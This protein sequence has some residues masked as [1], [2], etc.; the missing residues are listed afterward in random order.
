[1]DC[2]KFGKY[3]DNFESLTENERLSLTAHASECE[4]CAKELDF[5]MSVIETVKSLPKIEAPADFMERLN[6]RLDEEERKK[7][8]ASRIMHNMSRNWKQYTALAACLALVAVL[9]ANGRLLTDRLTDTGDGVIVNDT[10]VT[11]GAEPTIPPS[12]I[13]EVTEPTISDNSAGTET[14][15]V[16][17]T[18]TQTSQAAARETKPATT[19]VSRQSRASSEPAAVESQSSGTVKNTE[20]VES[21]ET[22]AIETASAENAIAAYSDEPDMTRGRSVN[23]IAG[24]T[25]S[26]K[27]VME[28]AEYDEDEPK[29]GRLKISPKDEK[30]AM[31][32][33]MKYSY[34]VD[35]DYYT[36][37]PDNMV[38]IFC[39][40][41]DRG[42]DY[43]NYT[44]EDYEDVITFQ[45]VIG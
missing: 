44:P 10:P 23:A 2:E 43:A 32:T 35:G 6:V 34:E 31:E 40:L 33:V 17:K 15:H 26:G 11:D 18:Q 4:R 36:T 20:T 22:G 8:L 37:S 14:E 7:K 3:L 30:D 16:Q 29:V 13:A 39:D 28:L 19:G 27:P 42:V 25:L 12:V 38:N 1:M 9:T 24:Y 21:V 41:V 45:L 5:M